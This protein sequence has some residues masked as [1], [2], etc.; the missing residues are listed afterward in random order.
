MIKRTFAALCLG[1]AIG[2]AGGVDT[3]SPLPEKKILRVSFY[4]AES[5]FDPAKISDL[6]SRTVTP[7]IFESLYAYDALARPVKI[8]PL[9]AAGMPEHSADFRIWT[10]R[11]QPGIYFQDDPAF[12]G[13]PR[14]LV[15]QDYIYSLKRFAD[16]AN[17]SPVV[18]TLLSTSIVGLQALRDDALKNKKPFDY[19]KPIEGMQALDRYTLRFKL[20][21]PR[22]RFVETLAAPDLFGAVA[23][24]VVEHYGDD[25]GAHPVGTGPFR[26]KQ[27]R[28]SSLI[29][30][31][32]NPQFRNM[33]YDAEPRAD[34]SEGQAILARMKGRRL[35]IVDEVH[36][37]IIEEHQPRWLAFLNGQTDLIGT[38]ASPLPNEFSSV[39]IP[40]GRLAP[41]LAKRGIRA[42]RNVNADVMFTMFN[43][44]DPVIGGY[45]PPQVALRRAIALSYDEPRAIRLLRKGQAVPAQSRVMPHTSGFDPAFKSE[46]SDY[47]PGRAK[48]LLD[49]YGFIDRDGDGWRERPDGSPLVLRMA[50]Q[51]EQRSRQYA[52]QWKK[53]LNAVG[54]RVEFEIAKWA[55]HL[56]AVRAG[57]LMMW[58]LGVSAAGP[59]GQDALSSM[60]GPQC[61]GQNM[62]CFKMPEF[63]ALYDRMS[64]LQDGPERDMLFLEAKKIG[65]AY[66]PYKAHAHRLDTDLVH[67]WLIGFRR[68]LFQT[69][70]WHRVDV[71]IALRAQ[72]TS[73][74][75]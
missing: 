65:A 20:E 42:I 58:S 37:S 69:E 61:R 62:S 51:P 39:A 27:W 52:E 31:E 50:T 23:R 70:W 72:R 55:E 32:R 41:N 33:T 64:E 9:T 73:A 43:M 15:A 57:K 26:L 49:L 47:N 28:R 53:D 6:F 34:D 11:L 2:S 63:D 60:Y 68:P 30:L 36:V 3:A 75:Q 24:E 59:D 67:P 56:K 18:S 38:D 74:V 22:P 46:M 14:E 25:V 44:E 12:K 40:G 35:P 21:K 48:A 8:R 45:T 5:T 66:M 17:K 7:H 1:L 10:V 4:S 29:V 54:I 13:R 16:P 71:D 19:D